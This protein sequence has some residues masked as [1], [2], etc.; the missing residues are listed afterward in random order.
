MRV[1]RYS[2][3]VHALL[4]AARTEGVFAIGRIQDVRTRSLAVNN[5]V[6][7][8]VSGG[9][10]AGLGVHVF[11]PD[12]L[13]GFAS[14]DQV[15]AHNAATLVRQAATLA[16]ASEA[17]DP[18]RN[19]A[20][21]DLPAGE[22]LV[23]R[24]ST[25]DVAETPL[26][27]QSAALLEASRQA[28]DMAEGFAVRSGHAV[29]DEEWRIVRSDGT[30]VSF[31]TPHAYARHDFTA[32]SAAGAASNGCS[33]SGAD[34]AVL[35]ESTSFAR[36]QRRASAAVRRARSVLDAPR[37][38]SGSYRLVLDYALAKGLAH[39]AFGHASETDGAETSILASGG[40]LRLGE[41]VAQP[42][43]SIIDGPVEGDYAFQPISANGVPRQTVHIIRDGVLESGLGDL[44]SA[45][46]AGSPITGADRA[47]SYRS[48]P[49]PRM[50]NIRIVLE[51]ARPLAV[52]FDEIEPADLR[53]I[54]LAE[55]L[56]AAGERVLF[57]SGYK[58]G[59]VNPKLGDFVF[60]CGAIFDFGDGA[61]PYQP[62]VF[63]GKSL[64][65]LRSIRGGIGELHLDA[66]GHCGKGGQSVPSS[67]GSHA[68]LLLEAHPEVLVGGGQ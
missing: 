22:T 34:A 18:E 30:D 65:A 37:V 36:L 41:Q 52:D 29:V 55:G 63:S 61:R 25:R 6:L 38:P 16:R 40:R 67:G 47:E 31:S 56:I 1:E 44:F 68:F 60:N 64:S 17:L 32:R 13:A 54:L 19:L 33:V 5:G 50:S 57:L 45:A 2:E 7:E 8:R 66:M 46:K 35:L 12:G 48:R 42:T 15:L 4:D 26:Q 21:Y 43:V 10:T 14:T 28:M 27:E 49:L 23:L 24:K 53:D 9:Q 39:E 62:A 3:T 58:G 20:V 59:Q 11:T 51:D